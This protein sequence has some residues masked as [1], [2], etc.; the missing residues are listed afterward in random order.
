MQIPPLPDNEESRLNTLHSLNI[1]DTDMEERFD[2]VTRM[3]K[4]MFQVPI[5]LVSLVDANRQWFKSCIG[6]DTRETPRDISFCGHT[7]LGNQT[8]QI[9]DA[10]QD[11]RFA[12]NPLVTGP[13]NIRFYAGHPLSAPNGDKL[14]TLCI[15]DSKPKQLDDEDL[16][17]L[18]DLAAMVEQELIAL[19][20][21]TMD[22]LTNISNRRGFI[23]LGQQSLG[24]CARQDIPACLIY[25]D[26]DNFKPINDSYGH[27]EGDRA[28]VIF[29]EVLQHTFRDCDVFARLGGDE[30]AVLLTNANADV[31]TA[32][33]TR[34]EQDLVEAC[35]EHHLEYYIVFTYGVTEYDSLEHDNI[36]AL[37]HS[38]D[39][40]MYRNK[41]NNR[42]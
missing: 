2:R 21:A 16:R 38:A 37:I 36:E 8:F 33:L 26:L 20:I 34:M 30:F 15:I 11:P 1:L 10:A 7:I 42:E 39:E 23:Q 14:G 6:L 41:K 35:K 12:D 5:A 19:Q 3:A 25:I 31:A 18:Q 13:P 24:L 32:V 9:P 28:L 4:R 27:K 17:A 22:A 40:A 29:A